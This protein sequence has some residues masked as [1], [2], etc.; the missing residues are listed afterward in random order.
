MVINM[1]ENG[2]MIKKED[3]GLMEYDNKDIYNGTW[4]NGNFK[5]KN[6]IF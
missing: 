6:N 3:K 1:M 2:L 5:W 4:K